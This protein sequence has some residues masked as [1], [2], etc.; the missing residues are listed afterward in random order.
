MSSGNTDKSIA[1]PG[2]D[3]S[4]AKPVVD[5]TV[6]EP[7]ADDSIAEPAEDRLLTLRDF[8]WP[9]LVLIG[10]CLA[11]LIWLYL[12][13]FGW[14]YT[15]WNM[16]DS[17]YS[18]GFLV[19][20]ISGFIVWLKRKRIMVTPVRPVFYGVLVMIPVMVWSLIAFWANAPS[21]QGLA[22]PLI[23]AA[24]SLALL[25]VAITRELAFP[26]GYLYFM[27]VLPTFLLTMASFRIQILS[28]MAATGI[29]KV[30]GFDAYREGAVITLPNI[31]VLVGAPCSGFR[32]L[33]SL[34]AFSVLFTYLKE[35]PWWGRASLILVTLPLSLVVN[36]IR[37]T[38]IA[39]VGEFFGSEAMHAFHD[40]SGYLVL[41]LAFVALWWMARLVRCQ[42]FN[43]MLSPS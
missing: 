8:R 6:V 23:L 25:G 13:T 11:L 42:K 31:E 43:S 35:G 12:P 4:I 33:I 19:P 38:L 14:W 10:A 7:V 5:D 32:L 2:A 24:M 20:L 3:R 15:M 27:A 39:M 1:K 22:F 41:V 30:M 18:H 16:E 9:T 17:Y 26:I 29:L 34:F 37:I 36:S 40:Y 28:T 21:I